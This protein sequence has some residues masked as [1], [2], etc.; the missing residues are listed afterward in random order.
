MSRASNGVINSGQG[1]NQITFTATTAGTLL[2]L[3]V[4][5]TLGSCPYGGGFANVTVAPVGQAVQ[6]YGVTPCRIVDTRNANGPLGGP[7]LA[8]SGGPDRAFILTGVCGIPAGATSVSANLTVVNPPF[9]GALAIY[10]GDG[11]LSGT[12][13]ISFNPAKVRAGNAILAL[14]GS[15]NV[16]VNNSSAGPVD[17][18]LDVDGYFQ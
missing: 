12:T 13:S 2:T 16:K 10:R 3:N 1:T 4:S 6:F 15:G 7:A 11:A 9:G 5:L 14:D 18:I 17:F 8:A